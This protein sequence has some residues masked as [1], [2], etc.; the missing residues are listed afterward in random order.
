MGRYGS[1]CMTRTT[2]LQQWTGGE[3]GSKMGL[4]HHARSA[5]ANGWFE[6]RYMMHHAV[7]ASQVCKIKWTHRSSCLDKSLRVCSEDSEAV[8]DGGL[9]MEVGRFSEGAYW[10]WWMGGVWRVIRREVITRVGC[11]DW[12]RLCSPRWWCWS[13]STARLSLSSCAS[14]ALTSRDCLVDPE[15]EAPGRKALLSVPR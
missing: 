13:S 6:E 9:V 4:M 7:L 8:V 5:K 2:A 14:I 1:Q 3:G 15:G 11:L 10:R 12:D